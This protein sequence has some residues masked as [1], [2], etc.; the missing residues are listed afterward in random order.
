M[1]KLSEATLKMAERLES[2]GT[3]ETESAAAERRAAREFVFAKNLAPRAMPR[4]ASLATGP[5]ASYIAHAMRSFAEYLP[6]VTRE[7]ANVTFSEVAAWAETRLTRWAASE[8]ITSLKDALR[9][10]DEAKMAAA[11]QMAEFRGL[12]AWLRFRQCEEAARGSHFTAEE[13]DLIELC[14]RQQILGTATA[15]LDDIEPETAVRLGYSVMRKITGN[16]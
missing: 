9:N 3:E 16:N 2:Q 7:G 5:Q 15:G 10:E 1:E 11:R 6:T 8:L 14:V 13:M 12:I 4:D